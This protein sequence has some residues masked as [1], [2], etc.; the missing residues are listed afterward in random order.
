MRG[1]RGHWLGCAVDVAL[2]AVGD[3]CWGVRVWCA[4]FWLDA[5]WCDDFWCC[6]DVVALVLGRVGL[7][8][9]GRW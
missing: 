1:A 8:R 9:A 7:V 5:S 2:V 3:R 4:V 6:A